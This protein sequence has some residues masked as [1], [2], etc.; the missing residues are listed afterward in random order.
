MKLDIGRHGVVFKDAMKPLPTNSMF[1]GSILPEAFDRAFMSSTDP[2]MPEPSPRHNCNYD[3]SDTRLDATMAAVNWNMVASIASRLRKFLT[4]IGLVNSREL[5][6]LCVS[7]IWTI[8][9]APCLSSASRTNLKRVGL[10]RI[11][12]QIGCRARP[13]RCNTCSYEHP[14][15]SYHFEVDSGGVE[16]PYIIMIKVGGV[17][18]SSIWDDMEDLKQEIVLRQVVDILLERFPPL[19]KNRDVTPTR[20]LHRLQERL[21]HWI[22]DTRSRRRYN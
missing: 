5:S 8:K 7:F 19:R 14:C 2:I 1:F 12:L 17:A 10:P 9:I 15:S 4:A 20:K 3:G 6:M 22:N 13:L 16:S 21:V 18:L 11:Y